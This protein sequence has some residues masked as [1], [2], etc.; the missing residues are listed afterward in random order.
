M[1]VAMERLASCGAV[2]VTHAVSTKTYDVGFCPK[3]CC[4]LG[5]VKKKKTQVGLRVR[6]ILI[7]FCGFSIWQCAAGGRM[8]E[9]RT[10]QK[11]KNKKINPFLP[12]K[13]EFGFSQTTI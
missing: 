9:R 7:Y 13:C 2:Y 5:P 10:H 12:W 4:I 11:I 3:S 8:E 6:G 1:G